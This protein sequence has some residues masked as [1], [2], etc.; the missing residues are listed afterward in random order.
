MRYFTCFF[1][2]NWPSY[3][4]KTE[5]ISEVTVFKNQYFPNKKYHPLV[6]LRKDAS[7]SLLQAR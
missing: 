4:Q 6:V 7:D 3:V 2:Q 5:Q 1:K